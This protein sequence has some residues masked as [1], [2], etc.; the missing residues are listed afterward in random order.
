[1][2]HGNDS[3][4]G[5]Q[6]A[7][8]EIQEVHCKK[9]LQD[10][11]IFFDQIF[12]GLEFGK[13]FPARESLVS[14]MPAGDRKSLNLYYSVRMQNLGQSLL[15]TSC[16]SGLKCTLLHCP[17]HTVCSNRK[18]CLNQSDKSRRKLISPQMESNQTIL[19]SRVQQFG[20]F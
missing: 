3:P 17:A 5:I 1:M 13:L 11:W 18:Q 8:H 14:D 12:L 4:D 6:K 2:I 15:E 16:M 20:Q 10:S 9:R 7:G 19:C